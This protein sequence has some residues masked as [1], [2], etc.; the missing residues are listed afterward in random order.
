[1]RAEDVPDDA[2]AALLAAFRGWRGGEQ[3]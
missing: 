2:A 1:L 3:A